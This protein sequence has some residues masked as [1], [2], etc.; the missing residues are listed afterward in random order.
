[1]LARPQ[2]G[3]VAIQ[4]FPRAE[5]VL[6]GQAFALSAW[7]QTPAE[8]EIQYQLSRDGKMISSGSKMISAGLN[9]LMFRDP[10]GAKAGVN[11]YTIA[12]QSA[13]KRSHPGK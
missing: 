9:R 13:K 8:Q 11:E 3:D 1:M 5:S 12:I 10:R 4:S 7:V 2:A 6:P